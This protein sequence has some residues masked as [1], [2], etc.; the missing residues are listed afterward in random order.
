MGA[1]AVAAVASLTGISFYYHAL[2]EV[3][4]TL[5][6]GPLISRLTPPPAGAQIKG[7]LLAGALE[8]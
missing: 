8:E 3:A 6:A 1:L 2:I 7:L 4:A 5:V